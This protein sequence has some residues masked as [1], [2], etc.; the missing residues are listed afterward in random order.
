[1]SNLIPHFIQEKFRLNKKKGHFDAYT[2][3]IDISG[4]TPLTQTLMREGNSGAEK[5]SHSLNQIFAPMVELVY[6]HNGFIPYFAGDAFTAVFPKEESSISPEEFLFAAQQIRDL[7]SKEKL[8]EKL[9]DGFEIGIKVGLSYGRVDW[10][11]VGK[12]HKAFYFRGKAID[13][14]ANCEHYAEG[15]DIIFDKEVMNRL[16]TNKIDV[17]T[18]E[19]GKRFFKLTN[20]IQAT[21]NTSKKSSLPKLAKSVLKKFLPVSVIGF[22]QRGEFRNVVSVFCKFEGVSTHKRLN[23]FATIVLEEVNRFSGYFKEIDFGDKGGILLGFFGA[24]V[25]FE[26]N[27]ERALECVIS[28]RERTLEL[29]E[30]WGLKYRAGITSGLAFTGIVGGKERCQYAAVGNWVNLAARLMISA[31]WGSVLVDENIQKHR[32]YIFKHI[33]DSKYKGIED[34]IPT[35]ELIGRNVEDKPVF[36]GN[37]IGREKELKRLIK[38]CEGIFHGE[39]AGIYYIYGEAGIGKTRLTFEVKRKLWEMGTP[40]WFACQADQILK[41]PLNPFIYFLKNYF[42]QSSEKTI[43][44]N[45]KNFDRRFDWLIKDVGNLDHP[46]ADNIRKELLRTKSII[47]A[48]VAIFYSNSLWEQ[49]D[50]KGRYENTLMAFE[51]IFKA[52]S[53]IRP[54]VIELEDGHWFDDDSKVFLKRFARSIGDYPIFLLV[55]SRY[56]DDGSKPKLLDESTL[57]RYQIPTKEEDLNILSKE[58]L[59]KFAEVWMKGAV[60]EEVIEML[61]K[62]TNGN[63]FYTE[64]I[65]EYLSETNML[66]EIDNIWN[67]KDKNVHITTSINSILMAR[68]DRLSNLA[69]ETV[70]AAA[71][72]GREF[73][74]PVLTEVM[75]ENHAFLERNGNSGLVLKQQIQTAEQGQIWRAMNDLRYIFK[76]SLLREAVYQMQLTTRLKE[77]HNL[78]ATAIEK[79]YKDSIEE[80]YVDL[81]FHYGQAKVEDKTNNYLEKAADHARRNFQNQQAL[82]FYNTLLRNVESANDLKAEIRI[83]LKKGSI[84]QLIGRW[85]E[86]EEV[87]QTALSIAKK[88]GDE[89]WLGRALNNLGRMLM[90]KGEYEKAKLSL[91]EASGFFNSLKDKHGILNVLG[92]L[93]NLNLRRGEYEKAKE[94]FIKSIEL[95]KD[96]KETNTIP[97]ITSNLGL[98]FMNLGNY[99][100]GIQCQL[101]WL[102]VSEKANDK[103]GMATLNTNV[104]IVYYEKGDYDAALHHYKK[105][106]ALSEELGNKFLTSIAIGCIGSVYQKKGDFQKAMD[107]FVRDLELA[108]ELGDKQG[109]AIAI[110]LI[111]ELRSVEGEFDI[112]ISYLQ[113]S[114]ELSEEL[115]YQ[116]GIAKAVN[117]LADIYRLQGIHDKAIEHYDRAI[118][119][120]RKINN[121]LVLCAS[122]I[123]KGEVLL[124]QENYADAIQVDEEAMRLAIELGNPDILF[125]AR[126]FSLIVSHHTGNPSVVGL[127]FE[128]FLKSARGA[129]EQA[130][131]YYELYKIYPE[132][133]TYKQKAFELY[134]Q[135]YTSIPQF[136]FETRMEELN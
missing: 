52:E 105:G 69:K 89:L 100:A 66:H 119:I 39:F 50:A 45:I 25:S 60:E 79:I 13:E 121:R 67:I 1:V 4:F 122:L 114:L 21:T 34:D 117:T 15:G 132:K 59:R 24:P 127:S 112:A 109:L 83:L 96:L 87:C 85:D 98:T 26:N 29:N 80:R 86:S 111:G 35:Y 10:G 6:N 74:V 123:E 61:Y 72:I 37:M 103:Q 129:E 43:S 9:L 18:E 41:K 56:N 63:P 91:E 110:G 28:I 58:S 106:L 88:L 134:K 107:H 104:G 131:V 101:E 130:A 65:L 27:I 23:K 90:L 38:F 102:E 11:I 97:Q 113:K 32:N 64:Q 3:F 7:F 22:D 71:V 108:E 48:Q 99:D 33:G 120:S 8:R 92:N 93:G 68:I 124:A 40:T 5:L 70:K 133:T 135:L 116:K 36:T 62:I 42:E 12:E 75:K 49:L 20:S 47:A 57:T 16:N 31:E 77:L 115:S 84:L 53:L 128:E 2:M 94:F 44:E 126:L 17:A 46:A 14:C 51:N 82:D 136:R 73:E 30:N 125:D 55:T 81:A 95:S 118:S 78:I 19:R 76:H 54:L